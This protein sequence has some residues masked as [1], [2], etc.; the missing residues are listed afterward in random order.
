MMSTVFRHVVSTNEGV[1]P[2]L[3]L[4]LALLLTKQGEN[5]LNGS[6][7]CCCRVVT[8]TRHV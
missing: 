3:T 4:V 6:A 8:V 2:G 5:K 7:W 1:Q